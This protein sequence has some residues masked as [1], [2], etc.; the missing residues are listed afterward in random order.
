MVFFCEKLVSKRVSLTVTRNAAQV[1]YCLEILEVESLFHALAKISVSL[2]CF[3]NCVAFAFQPTK[4]QQ[5]KLF[6]ETI[7]V[8]PKELLTIIQSSTN[9]YL[10]CLDISL[11]PRCFRLLK[12]SRWRLLYFCCHHI[13]QIY[14]KPTYLAT[15]RWNGSFKPL[16][17]VWILIYK[18][19]Q[20]NTQSPTNDIDFV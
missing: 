15:P 12:L 1:L 5:S 10:L 11:W 8:Y 13:F 18:Q 7:P 17:G 20:R 2:S 14:C 6:W 9:N 4:R 16:R 19:F 3:L